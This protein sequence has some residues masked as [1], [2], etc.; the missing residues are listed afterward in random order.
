MEENQGIAESIPLECDDTDEEEDGPS[1]ELLGVLKR[2][3]THL[4]LTADEYISSA[5]PP[6]ADVHAGTRNRSA[7]PPVRWEL[8]KGDR[9]PQDWTALLKNRINEQS[10]M[11]D[12]ED[13]FD[14]AT[15][16]HSTA[17]LSTCEP[18]GSRSTTSDLTEDEPSCAHSSFLR[19]TM[20][21][22][23]M[24][25]IPEPQIATDFQDVVMQQLKENREVKHLCLKVT[26]LLLVVV[27]WV[28]GYGTAMYFEATPEYEPTHPVAVIRDMKKAMEL[29]YN[30]KV[31]MLQEEFNTTMSKELYAVEL[32]KNKE[33]YAV[34]FKHQQHIIQ[35]LSEKALD[36]RE[37]VDRAITVERQKHQ[38]QLSHEVST[39]KARQEEEL[40]AAVAQA[41]AVEVE[42]YSSK[43]S[44]LQKTLAEEAVAH[45][46][47]V[48]EMLEAKHEAD[49]RALEEEKQRQQEEIDR[50]KKSEDDL[51][52]A[53]DELAK[54]KDEISREKDEQ[55]KENERLKHD[56]VNR[57]HN[58]TDVERL[59]HLEAEF[60]KSS[61]EKSDL[62]RRLQEASEALQLANET[63][64]FEFDKVIETSM[65]SL[66][67]DA[68]DEH[69]IQ[70]NARTKARKEI[71]LEMKKKEA[72]M[73][74]AIALK[75]QSLRQEAEILREQLST[76][77]AEE[78]ALKRELNSQ[79]Q[80][81]AEKLNM[82]EQEY[83]ERLAQK[84]SALKEFDVTSEK[85]AIKKTSSAMEEMLRLREK[86]QD[87]LQ[88]E[89]LGLKQQHQE[90]L[91][92][93]NV[94][95]YRGVEALKIEEIEV[96]F[97]FDG[98]LCLWMD[99]Q[100]RP[101]TLGAFSACV[102]DVWQ[103][104]VPQLRVGTLID[105]IRE[106]E[107][108]VIDNQ[109]FLPP[110]S[111]WVLRS[112]V[113]YGL[114]VVPENNRLR[115]VSFADTSA[116]WWRTQRVQLQ[117]RLMRLDNRRLDYL[118]PSELPKLAEFKKRPLKLMFQRDRVCSVEDAV[119]TCGRWAESGECTRNPSYMCVH[120]L[121]SCEC[122]IDN[123]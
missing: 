106:G 42:K 102:E 83:Q 34:E 7:G 35:V 62:M 105:E 45:L 49:K 2:R 74:D 65:S 30:Q 38:L 87:E 51:N 47:S 23:S 50:L 116:L 16:G 58:S 122:S 46:T 82:Q 100:T 71:E 118:S 72:E 15:Q 9:D 27:A 5:E 21:A 113:L 3:R 80:K 28:W 24:T 90:E 96:E 13:A 1:D 120:C 10:A 109:L 61:Q 73:K 11:W 112:E 32:N 6:H 29:Q 60:A 88:S 43:M 119:E 33:L 103:Q 37:A 14:A 55:R 39:V 114:N 79:E 52:R 108:I 99:P 48:K 25:S 41:K 57:P 68:L 93:I 56:L 75:E 53:K 36:Q 78:E 101:P 17:S 69:A 98:R 85:V 76:K 64:K 19:E 110:S 121:C 63:S 22:N 66:P 4:D 26:G 8:A 18:S 107:G 44:E 84:D 67:L 111:P 77:K 104:K 117:D 97:P 31:E 81:F 91:E 92:R 94:D 59:A 86:A 115:L 12:Y 89:L 54:A 40:K 70:E 123:I 20:L 95:R